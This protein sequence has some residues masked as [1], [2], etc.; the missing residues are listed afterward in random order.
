MGK[1]EYIFNREITKNDVED[2]NKSAPLIIT[3]KKY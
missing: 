2:F 3:I 1:K